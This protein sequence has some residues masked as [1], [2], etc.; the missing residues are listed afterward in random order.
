MEKIDPGTVVVS[1]ILIFKSIFKLVLGTKFWVV[2]KIF[3]K[4]IWKLVLDTNICCIITQKYKILISQSSKVFKQGL[5]IT[6]L[7]ILFSILSKKLIVPHINKLIKK[8]HLTDYFQ[9][10]K[11]MHDSP[12]S[13]PTHYTNKKKFPILI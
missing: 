8:N 4:Q 9:M 3:A 13:H 2:S 6:T 12:P 7:R 11:V 10:N 5:I 1:K